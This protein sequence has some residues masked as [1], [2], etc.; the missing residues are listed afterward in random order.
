MAAPKNRIGF[1]QTSLALRR[2]GLRPCRVGEKTPKI[3]GCGWKFVAVE[4][5]RGLTDE[6]VGFDDIK[7]RAD[8]LTDLVA[9]VEKR[10]GNPLAPQNDPAPAPVMTPEPTGSTAEPMTATE[11]EAKLAALQTLLAGNSGKVSDDQ[12]RDAIRLHGRNMLTEATRDVTVRLAELVEKTEQA[13]REREQSVTDKIQQALSVVQTTT[14]TIQAPNREPVVI[15]GQHAQFPVLLRELGFGNSVY[16]TGPAGSGKT[17]AALKCG[18]VLNRPVFLMRAVLDPFE[19]IGFIDGGGSYRDTQLYK[20]AKTPGAILIMD[21]IDRSNPKAAI[22]INS[23]WN[24]VI[25]FPHET[26]EVPP[27]NLIIAT[28]NTWGMGT[29]AEYVGSCRLDGATLDRFPT[30]IVW[31]YDEALEARLSG[32]T[33]EAMWIQRLRREA[34]KR[35]LRIILSPRTTIAHCKR[36]AGGVTREESLAVSVLASLEPEVRADLIREVGA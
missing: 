19:L 15:D 20:W 31:G 33:S 12:L 23:A 8:K 24:G 7:A 32:N 3:R 1:R 27:E 14:L 35:G 26:V 30:R 10:A 29:D 2:H 13:L 16:L 9:N 21:E 6:V 22:A 17:T 5:R 18:E 28:A 36:L 11:A 34:E 25:P 4:L